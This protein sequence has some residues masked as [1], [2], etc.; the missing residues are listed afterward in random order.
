MF[1]TLLRW[2]VCCGTFSDCRPLYIAI[3][4]QSGFIFLTKKTLELILWDMGGPRAI[5]S[6]VMIK[7]NIWKD[8]SN[9]SAAYV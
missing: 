3:W 9:Y 4:G 1:C 2:S 8:L 5:K 6:S 7:I